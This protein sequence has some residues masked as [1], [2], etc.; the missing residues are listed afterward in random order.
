M[1]SENSIVSADQPQKH[2]SQLSHVWPRPVFFALVVK[3]AGRDGAETASN[4]DLLERLAEEQPLRREDGGLIMHAS[5]AWMNKRCKP[6]RG[7]PGIPVKR[8][9]HT[10]HRARMRVH[11]LGEECSA[12]KLQ[13]QY[14]LASI[15]GVG[16]H[17]ADIRDFSVSTSHWNETRFLKINKSRPLGVFH[18]GQPV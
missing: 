6:S 16:E 2:G 15:L 5:D 8:T 11:A 10:A 7:V 17:L 12:M 4:W 1:V 9:G 18:F 3:N 14:V 13:L